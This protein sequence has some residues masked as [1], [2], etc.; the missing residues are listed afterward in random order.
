MYIRQFFSLCHV[1]DENT[2]RE[3]GATKHRNTET[4]LSEIVEQKFPDDLSLSHKG[5]YR[6]E[7][8]SSSFIV[9][10]LLDLYRP[11]L[12]VILTKEHGKATSLSLGFLIDKI[13]ILD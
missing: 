1:E 2:V 6:K 5:Y 7:G 3:I 11:S 8:K 9:S 12:S 13:R 4:W 10:V